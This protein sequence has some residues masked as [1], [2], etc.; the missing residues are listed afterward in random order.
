MKVQNIYVNIY[1]LR[2]VLQLIVSPLLCPEQF[3]SLNCVYN[4]F[5]RDE[6]HFL[7]S[8]WEGNV[9]LF[10]VLMCAD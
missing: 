8:K 5:F 4:I 1:V 9:P 2:F 10:K 7:L 3:Q 6:N